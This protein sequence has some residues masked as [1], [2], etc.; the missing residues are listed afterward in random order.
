MIFFLPRANDVCFLGCL[1]SLSK[2]NIKIISG[3]Y[4]WNKDKFFSDNS[5]FLK[6]KIYLPNPAIKEKEFVKK[7]FND[8]K[9][10]NIKKNK[11][12]FY[13]P[14][15]DT[16]MM[17]AINNWKRFKKYFKILGGKNFSSPNKSVYCK[18]SMYNFL[19]KI[20]IK[21]PFTEKFS[22][23]KCLE[24]LEKRM[25]IIVKPSFKDYSQC[26]YKNNFYKAVNITNVNDLKIFINKNKKFL[27]NLIIQE[28]I[29]FKDTK[30]ELPI[31]VYVNRHHKIIFSVCGVKWFI[32][33]DKYGTAAIL[34]I[35]DN[36]KLENIS[37]KIVKSLKWRG[38]LM[39]EFIFNNKNKRWEVIEMN[40]RPWLMID[41]FRRLNFSFLKLLIYD[42]MNLDMSKLIKEYEN[43][44]KENIKKKSM[45]VDLSILQKSINF[46]KSNIVKIK[47][48]L[49]KSKNITVST[50]D[51]DYPKPFE[52]EKKN[53]TNKFLKNI[54]T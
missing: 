30:H 10:I 43:N 22:K 26:F 24:L 5:K 12:I 31:Y 2:N 33:P 21:T 34:G 32:F 17:V 14:T 45:H 49:K 18:Y 50:F 9:K 39:I 16:N 6:Q 29:E 11:K 41:F 20:R 48:I 25:N 38:I 4:K 47:K 15:S 54:I 19:K 51:N 40:G 23:K 3:I 27:K 1:R 44:K 37:Q 46:K 28:H 13:L 35:D 7:L 8:L 52:L 53:I 42:Y 36:K